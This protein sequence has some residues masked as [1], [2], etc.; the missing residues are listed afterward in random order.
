M[1]QIKQKDQAAIYSPAI[2]KRR[3]C[4]HQV[5]VKPCLLVRGIQEH[6]KLPIPIL[7]LHLRLHI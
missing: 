6:I 7:L 1:T 2:A 5:P 4:L 3:N